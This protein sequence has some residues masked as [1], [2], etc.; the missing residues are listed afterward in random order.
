MTIEA[1]VTIDGVRT[2]RGNLVNVRRNYPRRVVTPGL[3]AAAQ[4][5]LRELIYTRR[6]ENHTWNLRRSSDIAQTRTRAGRFEP[7]YSLV[8]GGRRAPYAVFVNRFTRYFTVALDK[9]RRAAPAILLREARR[10]HRRYR[11]T[12]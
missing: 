11:P 2:L 9:M 7:G 8:S 5:G 6:Y 4:V 10:R 3:R 1:G 12:P